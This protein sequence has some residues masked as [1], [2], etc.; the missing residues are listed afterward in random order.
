MNVAANP[1]QIPNTPLDALSTG[2]GKK[3]GMEEGDLFSVVFDESA[4]PLQEEAMALGLEEEAL[5]EDEIVT[6]MLGDDAL[7]LLLDDLPE[8]VVA[9]IPVETVIEETSTADSE[10]TEE[11]EADL[12]TIPLDEMQIVPSVQIA[13]ED[14]TI[15]EAAAQGAEAKEGIQER[16]VDDFGLE[17]AEEQVERT[18]T[19]TDAPSLPDE[20]DLDV[21][22]PEMSDRENSAEIADKP[23]SEAPRKEKSEEISDAA[24]ETMFRGVDSKSERLGEPLRETSVSGRDGSPAAASPAEEV[25]RVVEFGVERPVA[26]TARQWS[27]QAEAVTEPLSAGTSSI[28]PGGETAEAEV[29]E[30]SQGSQESRPMNETQ[31]LDNVI[32]HCRMLTRPDGSS[33]IRLRLDPPELGSITLRLTLKDDHLYARVELQNSDLRQSVENLIPRI[34]EALAGDGLSLDRFDIDS[35]RQP[36]SQT[37]G[38]GDGSQGQSSRDGGERLASPDDSAKRPSRRPTTIRTPEGVMDFTV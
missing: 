3:A 5:S 32:R 26:D 34:R 10:T 22:E 4:A 14:V 17:P 11:V 31:L 23:R 37:G 9:D 27:G 25:A 30:R 19:E 28:A 16:A 6:A 13:L 38:N 33:E 24:N 15:K 35:R 7:V 1:A 12:E 21:P 20:T 29:A 36:E 18:E 8:D 2:K